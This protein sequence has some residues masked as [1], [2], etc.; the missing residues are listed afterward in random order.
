M[1][2]FS[3]IEGSVFSSLHR[4]WEDCISTLGDT[5]KTSKPVLL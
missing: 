2:I 4:S 3:V 5:G 1:L